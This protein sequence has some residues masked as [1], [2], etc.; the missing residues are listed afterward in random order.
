M[1]RKKLILNIIIQDKEVDV[2][3]DREMFN[4]IISK[5]PEFE[6]SQLS[7]DASIFV[8][9]NFDNALCKVLNGRNSDLTRVESNAIKDFLLPKTI[10]IDSDDEEIGNVHNAKRILINA[11][12]RR[13][14]NSSKYN[15]A[16]IQAIPAT[17]CD[18]ERPFS[19]AGHVLNKF[20]C[21][22]AC[23]VFEARMILSKNKSVWGNDR[24]CLRNT[25]GFHLMEATI[26]RLSTQDSL[27]DVDAIHEDE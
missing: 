19:K 16:L 5:Y 1:F 3:T 10:G 11:K 6:E 15:M 23:R 7:E 9:N 25:K 20:R 14:L 24:G 4:E 8:N 2:L 22:M 17:S 12:K 13:K 21:S 18:I 27:D 26:E